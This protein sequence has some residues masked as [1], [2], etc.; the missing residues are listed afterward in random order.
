MCH[1]TLSEALKL[2]GVSD[3]PAQVRWFFAN[4]LKAE[5]EGNTKQAEELLR[6]AVDWEDG[7][8]TPEPVA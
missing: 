6:L 1:S 7:L 3:L 2:P 8:S 5:M 4:A